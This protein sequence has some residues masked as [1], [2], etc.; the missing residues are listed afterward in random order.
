MIRLSEEPGWLALIAAV[1]LDQHVS[2]THQ[3]P[4]LSFLSSREVD[5]ELAR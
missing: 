3:I 2:D 1:Y 5:C 4:A